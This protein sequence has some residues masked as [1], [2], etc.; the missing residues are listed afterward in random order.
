MEDFDVILGLDW[1]SEHNVTIE[2]RT[3]SVIFGNPQSA[4]LVYQDT[5]PRKVLKIISALKAHKLL[6]HGC[7]GF[8]A[9]VKPISS[10]EPTIDRHPVICEYPDVFQKELPGLPPDREVEFTIDLIPGAEPISKVPYR[11]APLEL[12]ELKEQLQ[13]LLNLGFIR[14]SVSP[15]GAPVLFL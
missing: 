4:E 12:K 15:W 5:Q 8:L 6:L 10:E 7:A 13:E 1:L 3:R 11:M 9:S 14:P 2:C